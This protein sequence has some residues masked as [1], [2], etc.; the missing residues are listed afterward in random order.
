[1]F[2][3]SSFF[4]FTLAR[5]ALKDYALRSNN[6]CI[7]NLADWWQSIAYRLAHI[8]SLTKAVGLL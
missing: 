4:Q 7:H 5:R 2:T 3:T 6:N 1:M 8:A